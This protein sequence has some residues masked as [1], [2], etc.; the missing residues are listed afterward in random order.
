MSD[1]RVDLGQLET[2]YNNLKTAKNN[3][4]SAE[5]FSAEVSS[6]VGHPGLAYSVQDFADKWNDKR[7]EMVKSVED[8]AK[9]VE[10]TAKRVDAIHDGFIQAN[11]ALAESLADGN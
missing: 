2:L 8:T 5:R 11:Q 10:D 1:I 7:V 9:S 4:A 3:F 6:A